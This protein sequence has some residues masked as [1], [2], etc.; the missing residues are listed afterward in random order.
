LGVVG[1]VAAA[2]LFVWLAVP[3]PRRADPIA[4]ES[5]PEPVPVHRL[6]RRMADGDDP[7]G[8][9][10][11]SFPHALTG[12]VDLLVWEYRPG[13]PPA[14]FP[15]AYEVRFDSPPAWGGGPPYTVTGVPAF[16]PDRRRRVSGVPG[17]VVLAAASAVDPR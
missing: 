13:F 16:R 10:L 12:I 7:P 1:L 8:R 14:A 2:T 5:P 11:V 9:V 6:P 15:P 17:V 4:A 3:P